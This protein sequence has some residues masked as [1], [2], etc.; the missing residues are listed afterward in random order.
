MWTLAVAQTGLVAPQRGAGL[1]ISELSAPSL[2]DQVK[3]LRREAQP[4]H[5]ISEDRPPGQHPTGRADEVD[6]AVGLE[7][8][9]NA[10]A[11]ATCSLVSPK[12]TKP[13]GGRRACR[14]RSG[15]RRASP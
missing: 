9:T 10:S 14:W 3:H 11:A 1:T 15:R 7:L 5:L 12:G 2:G 8:S 6:R 13:E 4:P